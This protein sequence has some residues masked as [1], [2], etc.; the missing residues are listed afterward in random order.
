MPDQ[1]HDRN[2]HDRNNDGRFL[3]PLLLMA[4]IVA[5]GFLIYA[6]AGHALAG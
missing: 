2:Q 4:L 1:H 6:Y 5:V 3:T